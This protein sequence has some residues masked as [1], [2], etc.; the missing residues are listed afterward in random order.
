[1]EPIAAYSLIQTIVVL[2]KYCA[3]TLVYVYVYWTRTHSGH[4]NYVWWMS[5][6]KV[7][8]ACSSCSSTGWCNPD[9]HLWYFSADLCVFAK[10]ID[11]TGQALL[12]CH[13]TSTD[14]SASSV[15]LIEDGASKASW[16]TVTG[17]MPSEDGSVVLRLTAEISLSPNTNTFGCRV[18]TGGHNITVFWGES[19]WLL[20]TYI[21]LFDKLL[22]IPVLLNTICWISVSNILSLSLYP[23]YIL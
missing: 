5:G 3:F 11:N 16:I 2:S 18:Q 8:V 13:V 6:A 20:K 19:F 4:V 15:Y 7:R 9:H 14:K 17:P 10:P 1:M 22:G 21:L 12:T 23:M